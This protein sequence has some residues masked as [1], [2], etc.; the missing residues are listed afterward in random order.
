MLMNDNNMSVSNLYSSVPLGSLK[1]TDMFSSVSTVLLTGL[2]IGGISANLDV[3]K[4]INTAVIQCPL[5]TA[6]GTT[7]TSRVGGKF[8]INNYLS[9]SDDNKNLF[10]IGY[11]VIQRVSD[12]SIQIRGIQRIFDVEGELY[13]LTDNFD[14]VDTNQYRISMY[15][16]YARVVA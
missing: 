13:F 11:A 2:T 6:T 14:I 16:N 9:P 8:L 12:N 10:H 15:L 1:S 7:S 5:L 3:G 4:V